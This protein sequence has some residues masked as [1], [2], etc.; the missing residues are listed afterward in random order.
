MKRYVIAVD[1]GTTSARAMLF[2]V[3]EKKFVAEDQRSIKQIYPRPSWVEEDADEI[4]VNTLSAIVT[5]CEKADGVNDVKGIGITNQRETVIAWDRETG[6]PVYNAIVWQCRRTSGYCK[7][8]SDERVNVIKE[9][10]GLK[11]DAYFSA[12]KIKWIIDNVEKAKELMSKGRLCVGTVDSFLI[13]KLT[14]N[15]YT[16]MTNASR[17]M[18][19]NLHTLSWD[20]ELLEFFG[21]PKSV[22]PKIKRCDDLFGYFT[23]KGRNIPVTGVLGD[24]QAALYGQDCLTAGSGKIT[25]GT[26]LFMLF[27]T[28]KEIADSDSALSTVGFADKNGVTYA[29][30]GSVFNAGSAVQ[31][32]RDGLGLFENSADTEEMA[33]SVPDTGGVYVV[34]A[35]TGLG[36]PYWRGD[37]TGLI[38]GITRGTNK[39]HITR[40]VLESIAYS[41]KAV[42]CEIEKDCGFAVKE[43]KV[44]G[45]ASAND[46]LMQF[47][48]D[49]LNV[50]IDRP[51][52]R[53]S[54][55]LGAAK[56]CAVALGLL[57]PKQAKEIRKS[58][59]VFTPSKDRGKYS[60][61]YEGYKKAVERCLF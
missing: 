19:F 1:E 22:L 17:T 31:W 43:I 16:D 50:K 53:E 3:D 56:A 57:S 40:A 2:D 20:D 33:K 6:R 58:D 14:G 13:Y 44:D 61:L 23:Y 59:K 25:Y 42:L 29:L 41:A 49:I 30:E 4:Y 47:Q 27:S 60:S 11:V 26:G 37:V 55:A 38:T 28:G 5:M 36:A 48:A 9:K 46:F 21:I 51:T 8:L 7:T 35:F 18:L 34:P 10:T 15:F 32:L 45:G 52:E 24:Q 39:N 12:T 54:T